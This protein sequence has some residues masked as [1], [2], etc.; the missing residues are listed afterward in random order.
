MRGLR[1]KTL[2]LYENTVL[3]NYYD[4]IIFTESWLNEGIA[5]GELFDSQLYDV[6]RCDRHLRDRGINLGGGVLI[7]TAKRLNAVQFNLNLLLE[8]RKNVPSIDILSVKVIDRSC[9]LFLI[10]VYV[11]PSCHVND[12]ALLCDCLISLKEL[13]GSSIVIFGDFNLPVLFGDEM[14]SSYHEILPFVKFYNLTQHNNIF[15][16]YNRMLDFVFYSDQCDVSKPSEILCKEDL[17]HPALELNIKKP[18]HKSKMINNVSNQYNFKKANF[19]SLYKALADI[20][21][22]Y[23]YVINDL[24]EAVDIMYATLGE[25]FDKFV[26]KKG[27]PLEL[28]RYGLLNLL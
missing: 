25:I 22:N 19:V 15:N 5:S 24:Q 17:H 2:S 16:N 26:P 1:T 18:N 3:C 4:A 6:F 11:P 20:N 27:G 28:I 23:F 12:Y 14:K 7:A 10:V 9:H 8:F 21:W 13:Y